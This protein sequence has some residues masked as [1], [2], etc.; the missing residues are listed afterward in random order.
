MKGLFIT[1]EGPDGSGK[2]TQIKKMANLLET[3]RLPY[4]LTREPGGTRISDKIREIILDPEHNELTEETE[5]LLYASSRAQHVQEKIIPAL[6]NG[7]IVLCDRFMDAS[8][9]YQGY[10]L[11]KDL[12]TIK[13]INQFASQGLEPDRTYFIDVTPETGRK[14]MVKRAGGSHDLDRIELREKS[15]HQRVREGFMTIYHENSNRICYIDGEKD[16]NQVFDTIVNDFFA[17]YSHQDK[18]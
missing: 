4:I 12:Q 1:F 13:S 6:N 5:I 11:G 8:I 2:S 15:Y 17:Y 9:A 10:G 7:K 3:K 14:R 16:L 18:I